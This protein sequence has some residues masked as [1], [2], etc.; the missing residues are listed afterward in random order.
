MLKR[1]RGREHTKI[2]SRLTGEGGFSFLSRV[3]W[4]KGKDRKNGVG[5]GMNR[6]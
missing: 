1:Y 4:V 3:P 2:F 6:G 5:K